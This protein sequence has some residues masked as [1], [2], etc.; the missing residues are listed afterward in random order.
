MGML[1]Y[2][3]RD[4]SYETSGTAS[5]ESTQQIF[6]YPNNM[7]ATGATN[8]LAAAMKSSF[9]PNHCEDS[10]IPVPLVVYVPSFVVHMLVPLLCL[11]FSM[12]S[13]DGGLTGIL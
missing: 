2:T 6:G 3:T 11:F 13:F 7:A 8:A 10:H 9:L 12:P 1:T 4:C 5:C